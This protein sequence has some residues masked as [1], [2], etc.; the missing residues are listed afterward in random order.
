[1]RACL[2]R[3]D[4]IP[5]STAEMLPGAI[6]CASCRYRVPKTVEQIKMA[7]FYLSDLE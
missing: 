2:S 5:A 4:Y 1:M 3:R 7:F 6:D